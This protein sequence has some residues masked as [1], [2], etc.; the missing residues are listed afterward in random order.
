M[1]TAKIQG[2]IKQFI[3]VLLAFSVLMFNTAAQMQNTSAAGLDE[4]YIPSAEDAIPNFDV[5]YFG[6]DRFTAAALPD[7]KGVNLK[8]N[9]TNGGI[10]MGG[11]KKTFPLNGLT[12]RFSNL[13][14]SDLGNVKYLYFSIS[15]IDNWNE[16]MGSNP[17]F[18]F[19][20]DITDGSIYAKTDGN[21][22]WIANNGVYFT[23]DCLKDHPFTIVFNKEEGSYRVN[24]VIEDV[25]EYAYWIADDY[26]KNIADPENIRIGLSLA[27]PD[28]NPNADWQCVSI[29][30]NAVGPY[31]QPAVSGDL[32][33]D[34]KIDAIDLVLMRDAIL[35][36]K[37]DAKFDINGT[38]DI[39]IL[40]LVRLK[41]LVIHA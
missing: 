21:M 33:D 22:A 3:M 10:L 18:A 20:L 16:P 2:K 39:D 13:K 41:K 40:D 17:P 23:Y 26:F 32:N 24:V 19:I 9:Y 15:N 11:I 7:N 6:S 5:S 34:G 30:L 29:D 37:T 31:K 1:K 12:M 28:Y 38:D 36:G 8:L 14:V 27:G 25:G 4:L 35:N